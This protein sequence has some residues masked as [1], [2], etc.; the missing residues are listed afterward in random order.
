MISRV[1]NLLEFN[2]IR[3]Q[4]AGQAASS[5]GREMAEALVPVA[6]LSDVTHLIQ[7]TDEA[8]NVQ[9]LKGHLPF[10]GITDVRPSLKRAEIGGGLNA[11]E[12]VAIAD[13]I[14]GSRLIKQFIEELVSDGNTLPLLAQLAEQLEPPGVVERE[15]R[16][17]I[18]EQGYV[19]DSAS[20]ALRSVRSQIRALDGRIKDKLESIVRSPQTQKM[21]SEALVTIR[22][23]RHVVP[24]KQE[25][26]QS[27]GGIVHDQS[28][29]G[30]TFFIEPQSIV[31]LN[32]RLNEARHNE[33]HE[34]DKI[35][36]RLSGNVSEVATGMRQDVDVLAQFDFI[37]AKAKLAEAMKATKPKLGDQ[38]AFHLKKARHPLIDP[39]MVVPIDVALENGTHALVIT[40]PNTG[41]KTVTLKTV[42]LLTLMAQSGLHIP[43]NEGSSVNVFEHIF[44]D[45]GDEQSIEQSLSTFSSHMTN[46]VSIIEQVNHRSLVL[47]DELGAGTDPQEGAALS[48]AILDEV[49]QKGRELNCNNSL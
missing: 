45:I 24:V 23:N 18:D 14:R 42:G 40:G 38:G 48:I 47:F 37:F 26:R 44:A 10:G 15:I 20:E 5:L 19:M 3:T 8:L 4:L 49:R 6:D 16:L 7:E 34:I 9:R 30:A 35:L 11:K 27:F 21:L 31:D 2:K 25:Y 46:I 12:L 33:Q 22:N 43:A 39:N 17:C 28:A 36:T 1:L 32:N 13:V 41:G 29:S